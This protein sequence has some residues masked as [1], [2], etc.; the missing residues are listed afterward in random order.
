[1]ADSEN[2]P[3]AGTRKSKPNRTFVPVVLRKEDYGGYLIK[4]GKKKGR[5]P[6]EMTGDFGLHCEGKVNSPGRKNGHLGHGGGPGCLS[7]KGE[8]N[9]TKD[10]YELHTT[11]ERTRLSYSAQ[12]GGGGGGLLGASPSYAFPWR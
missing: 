11:G 4:K 2:G 6:W 9:V 8:E 3:I 1:M 7:I 10:L 12:R 5:K